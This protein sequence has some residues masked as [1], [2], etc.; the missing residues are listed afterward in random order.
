MN[1]TTAYPLCW[2]VG[3]PREKSR[4]THARFKATFAAARDECLLEISRLGGSSAIIS[5]N[6]A[7]KRDGTPAAVEW[8]KM[9]PDPGVA[10]YFKRNGKDLCFCCDRWNH[11]QDNMRA[12][13]LTIEALRGIS[14]WGTGDMME[15]AF[16]GFKQLAESSDSSWWQVLGI[17]VNSSPEQVKEAYRLLAK[18]FHPDLKNQ[19]DAEMFRRVQT[20]WENFERQFLK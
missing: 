8:G 13:A 20:A 5:T 17:P 10:V 4:A 14:R 6:I 12:V 19:P 1:E 9:I 15:A 11:V 2:P 3:R 7:L 16:T 18:K